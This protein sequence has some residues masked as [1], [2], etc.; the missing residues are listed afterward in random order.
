M[1]SVTV[2]RARNVDN[3]DKDEGEEGQSD[4]YVEL[5]LKGNYKKENTKTIYD[6][7]NPVWQEKFQLFVDDARNDVLKAR[8]YDRDKWLAD[9]KIGEVHIPVITVLGDNG[10]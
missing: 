5:D 2:I 3:M 1:L 10:H 6:E 4:P 7:A 8:V 9:D